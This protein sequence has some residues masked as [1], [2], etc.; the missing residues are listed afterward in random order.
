MHSVQRQVGRL[1]ALI[2]IGIVG[3]AMGRADAALIL[4]IDEYTTDTL[5][6]TISGTFDAD[7]I[8]DSE[9]YLAL[10]N[11]WSNN[12][13]FHTEWFSFEPVSQ[14]NT[15]QIGGVTPATEI[16]NFVDT[17]TDNV[18]WYFPAFTEQ[19]FAA[20]TAVS[21]SMTLFGVG[22][23][24]PANAST[25]QL[26]SGF[27]RPLDHDDW[28]RL[29]ATA[30]TPSAPEPTSLLLLSLGIAGVAVKARRRRKQAQ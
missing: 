10:K 6:F 8:G 15:I 29:E 30:V 26:V 25:L 9:G 19:P 13:G 4:T 2:A 21:G 20:G 14:V 5:S 7:T 17:W 23:F 16:Q 28:A 18:F 22:A 3:P 11:D 1:V 12:V 27:N 24:N